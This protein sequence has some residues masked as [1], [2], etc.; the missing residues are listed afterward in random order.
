MLPSAA[1]FSA[2]LFQDGRICRAIPVYFHGTGLAHLKSVVPG[3]RISTLHPSPDN[4]FTR[5]A[6]VNQKEIR[7]DSRHNL[8]NCSSVDRT[9]RIAHLALQC[10]LGLLPKRR[11]G[12][13]SDHH[14]GIGVDGAAV[15]GRSR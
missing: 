2:Q 15:S 10:W 12:A 14:S 9:R 11:L 5:M 8:I 13:G 1:I 7:Y 3:V 6:A 4:L